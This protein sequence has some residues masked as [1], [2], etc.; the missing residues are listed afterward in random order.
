MD[1][2]ALKSL[3]RRYPDAVETRYPEPSNFLAYAVRGRDFAYFK[4]SQPERWR[5]SVRVSSDRFLAL[6][7]MPGVKPA[8][9]RGRWHWVTIV[10]VGV[11]PADY[12][13][14]LV[15][16]SYRRAL[17]GAATTSRRST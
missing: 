10:K 16:W 7:D 5:F 3:C 6:I 1:V 2:R 13:R 15:A 11:F 17:R 14:E 4:T 9:Y 12:L 8:R